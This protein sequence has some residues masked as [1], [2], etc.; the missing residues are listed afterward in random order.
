[1]GI[2]DRIANNGRNAP[3]RKVA[4]MP[5]L[6]IAWPVAVNPMMPPTETDVLKRDMPRPNDACGTR[7]VT[8]AD[9]I[10]LLTLNI[11]DPRQA[12][13]QKCQ[14]DT[15]AECQELFFTHRDLL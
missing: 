7:S 6:S 1:M 13:S 12:T 2:R 10:A 3:P 11:K 9:P 5:R 14:R 8:R 15:D 4:V